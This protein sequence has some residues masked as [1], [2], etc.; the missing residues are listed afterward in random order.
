MEAFPKKVKPPSQVCSQVIKCP[1]CGCLPVSNDFVFNFAHSAFNVMAADVMEIAFIVLK[2]KL[3]IPPY[4]VGYVRKEVIEKIKP[5]IMM[6]AEQ[7][8]PL[9]GSKKGMIL[10]MVDLGCRAPETHKH[11][12]Y[13]DLDK[14]LRTSPVE[15]HESSELGEGAGLPLAEPSRNTA[16]LS[17]SS[18]GAITL[19]EAASNKLNARA[20][21]KAKVK[22]GSIGKAAKAFKE[23]ASKAAMRIKERAI[24]IK[25]AE[26]R[27]LMREIVN[28]ANK[29]MVMVIREVFE[30]LLQPKWVPILA[31][32]RASATA[33]LRRAKP[34]AKTRGV[35]SATHTA[36]GWSAR[37]SVWQLSVPNG[38][39]MFTRPSYSKTRKAS[40]I[41]VASTAF[42]SKHLVMPVHVP[43]A[44][45]A[46]LCARMVIMVV[47]RK[48]TVVSLFWGRTCRV[49]VPTECHRDQGRLLKACPILYAQRNVPV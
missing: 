46:S 43:H 2:Q 3:V 7:L 1:H 20:R 40:A 23:K 26:R 28:K 41:R 11:T 17:A 44:R 39:M 36:S 32:G 49:G 4:M 45:T 13:E 33:L 27:R 31:G 24:K 35:L 22:W 38:A 8:F 6:I 30:R 25:E 12:I 5:L 47:R 19:K 15:E 21:G 14:P 37:R 18:H 16:S 10:G 29:M 48:N 42:T 34:A 9:T